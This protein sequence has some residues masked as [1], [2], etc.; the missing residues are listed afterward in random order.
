M[1]D[2]NGVDQAI[3]SIVDAV[4]AGRELW[5]MDVNLTED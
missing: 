1:M 4:N 2:N 5:K 3:E